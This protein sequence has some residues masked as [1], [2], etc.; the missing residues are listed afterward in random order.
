M[1][2]ELSVY[3]LG[4]RLQQMTGQTIAPEDWDKKRQRPKKARRKDLEYQTRL[5]DELE[6]FILAVLQ[7]YGER[8]RL[9]DLTPAKLRTEVQTFLYGGAR[10]PKSNDALSW[11][12]AFVKG[13]SSRKA[14]GTAQVR[15]AAFN[16]LSAFIEKRRAGSLAFEEVDFSFFSSFRD[17]L[18][19]LGLNDNTVH[20]VLRNAKRFFKQAALKGEPV[21]EWNFSICNDLGV[22]PEE[23]DTIRLHQSQLIAL[24]ME[25]PLPT[26]PK[27]EKY[28]LPAHLERVRDWFL[29]ACYTGARYGDWERIREELAEAYRT[30][31]RAIRIVTQKTKTRVVIPIQPALWAILEK[32]AGQLPDVP[33]NQHFNREIK[34]AFRIRGFTWMTEKIETVKGRKVVK[35]IPLY[36]RIGSHSGRRIFAYNAYYVWKL[37]VSDIMAITGHATEL[38]CR[39]YIGESLEH[40]ENRLLE[41]EIFNTPRKPPQG[42]E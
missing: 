21:K 41:H 40:T 19:S 17:Y 31:K 3:W 33:T 1:I 27:M 4:R 23:S 22:C 14:K 6:T 28:I 5:L 9:A 34:E 7:T 39:A 2:I 18:F 35:Q 42:D 32:Y 16:H 8:R 15:T 29:V 10:I 30:G 12:D 25:I 13:E 20:K 38:Q 26:T 11:L 36:E 24:A 37:P